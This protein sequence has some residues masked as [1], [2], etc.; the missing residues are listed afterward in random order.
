MT[1]KILNF[2]FLPEGSDP[3]LFVQQHGKQA[4]LDALTGAQSCDDFLFTHLDQQYE[5]HSLA[6]KAQYASAAQEL[7]KLVPNG[8][9]HTMLLDRLAKTLDTTSEQLAQMESQQHSAPATAPIQQRKSQTG[10]DSAAKCV[11]LLLHHPALAKD[12]DIDGAIATLRFQGGQK[13]LCYVAHEL[14]AQAA[15]NTAV[16]LRAIDNER[17][18]NHLTQMML[19]PCQ[20]DEDGARIELKD[21]CIHLATQNQKSH[22]DQMLELAKER[23]LTD[24]ERQLLKSLLE[25][26]HEPAE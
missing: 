25:A 17:L 1:A 20:L 4:F 5:R 23:P 16:L 7:I 26:E 18:S 14:A 10:F 9:Y 11:H 12:P 15:P 19:K 13:L 2:L 8:L 21:G 24:D 3:D 6:E 22:I